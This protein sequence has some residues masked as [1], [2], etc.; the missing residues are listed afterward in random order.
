MGASRLPPHPAPIRAALRALVPVRICPSLPAAGVR[1]ASRAC[2][3]DTA[4][5]TSPYT[6]CG[7]PQGAGPGRSRQTDSLLTLNGAP[8]LTSGTCN[9]DEAYCTIPTPTT[10]Q[11]AWHGAPTHAQPH[12]HPPLQSTAAVCAPGAG[13]VEGAT[14]CSPCPPDAYSRGFNATV[15]RLPCTP[16]RAGWKTGVTPATSPRHCTGACR[17]LSLIGA[18]ERAGAARRLGGW[19][20]CSLAINMRPAGACRVVPPSTSSEQ[21]PARTGDGP[22]AC[23]APMAR[24]RWSARQ[25]AVDA[26]G[27]PLLTDHY[28][29]YPGATRGPAHPS[30]W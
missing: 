29:D 26:P 2:G 14:E 1:C 15:P 13:L 22:P 17:S 30:P 7:R 16:C 4:G 11:P 10:R 28:P 25:H 27:A 18:D 9:R 24:L 6:C 5:R 23:W 20:A 21:R 12:T 8:I 19:A 3:D